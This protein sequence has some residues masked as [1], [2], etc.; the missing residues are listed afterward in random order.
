MKQIMRQ[1]Y[2]TIVTTL[3]RYRLTR[4]YPLNVI[5]KWICFS[6]RPDFADVDGHKMILDPKDDS[7]GLSINSVYEPFETAYFKKEIKNGDVVFDIGANI[8]YFT[9]IFAKLVGE[10]GKVYAFEPSPDVFDILKKNVELNG[11]KNVVLLKKA[12]STKTEKIKLYVCESGASDNHIYNSCDNRQTI[13]IDAIALDDW[14][15]NYDG[16]ID[17]IKMDVQGAEGKALQGMTNLLKT[18]KNIKMVSEF[19]PTGL[20]KSGIEPKEYL[21]LLINCGF[22]LY[23]MN[24]QK[25]II[26]ELNISKVLESYA[27][28][29][30]GFTNILCIKGSVKSAFVVG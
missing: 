11:Y 5:H 6:L 3:G 19:W 14:F 8:G 1:A 28:E 15:K 24:E 25:K 10:N 21:N 27:H 20:I 23:E 2:K 22:K 30:G 13:L 16:K 29:K 12:V 7:L 17:F 26:E 18:R 4:F 9:L